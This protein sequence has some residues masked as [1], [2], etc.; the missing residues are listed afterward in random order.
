MIQDFYNTYFTIKRAEWTTD[1]KENPYSTEIE[2]DD[3]YGQLQQASPELVESLGMNFTEAYSI[4]CPLDT[5]VKAG[6]TLFSV[7]GNFSVRAIQKYE[8][9]LNKHIQIVARL[10]EVTGS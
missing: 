10:D 4:W 5:N 3:F 2:V 1:D 9:G 6:D 7:Q 8:N